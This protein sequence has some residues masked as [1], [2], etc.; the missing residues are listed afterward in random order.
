[1]SPNWSSEILCKGNPFEKE[2]E[3][4]GTRAN[5]SYASSRGWKTWRPNELEQGYSPLGPNDV[6]R[7]SD[8]KPSSQ[9]C[10]EKGQR[11][12]EFGAKSRS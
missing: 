1:M 12:C 2:G 9:N 8:A 5:E 3:Q 10:S 6:V 4:E 11:G 7:F